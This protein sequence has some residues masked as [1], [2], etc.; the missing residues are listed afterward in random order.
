MA[1]LGLTQLKQRAGRVETLIRLFSQGHS[2]V[3]EKDDE[4]SITSKKFKISGIILRTGRGSSIR[5]TIYLKKD[6]KTKQKRAALEKKILAFNG[7][8]F[9]IGFYGSEKTEYKIRASYVSKSTEFGGS[10]GAAG[11][12]GKATATSVGRPTG[13]ETLGVRAETLILGGKLEKVRYGTKDVECRT[14][15]TAEQ[16]SKSIVNGLEKNPKIPDYIT[17]DF[18]KYDKSK[19]WNRFEWNESIP[20][21]EM[22]Q[23]GK[24]A[25]EVITGLIGLSTYAAL[26]FHPNIL[27]GK[28]KVSQFCVPTDPAF[29]GV[30]VFFCMKDGSI[31]PVSNKYG[32]GAAASFF[33]NVMPEA[34]SVP[35][36]TLSDSPLKDLV[37]I[38]NKLSS[39]ALMS[40]GGAGG[41]AKFIIYE[42]GI[43]NILGISKSVIKDPYKDIY[44]IIRT[45]K[46]T[47]N[48]T[49]VVSA[50]KKYKG[51]DAVVVKN[52]PASVTAFFCREIAKQFNASKGANEDMAKI[53]AG[54]NYWQANLND[55]KWFKGDVDYRLTNS[56]EVKINVIG[57]KAPTTDI[58]AS[59]GLVNYFMETP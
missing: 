14:F 55:R 26:A 11:S 54:K 57:S 47:P 16:I 44:E 58:V 56:G 42:Y 21:N 41:K 29:S 32:K 59:Q 48:V 25:G 52:L 9:Y 19:K 18:K 43:R 51:V 2:F 24:Y 45:G 10:A 17:D 40:K 35:L 28:G 12:P 38:A 30:D 20:K 46:T 3:M 39:I 6:V 49:R 22:N 8:L 50:I 15:T 34:M 27:S 37:K 7:E 36:K 1:S 5:E 53:L 13:S 31:I 23:L 4:G 33:T